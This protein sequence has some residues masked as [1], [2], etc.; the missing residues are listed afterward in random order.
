MNSLD[1]QQPGGRSAG[2]ENRPKLPVLFHLLDVSRPKAVKPPEVPAIPEPVVVPEPI[3]TSLPEPPPAETISLAPPQPQTTHLPLPA[4][5]PVYAADLRLS[6]PAFS[7]PPAMELPVS[8][9]QPAAEPVAETTTPEVT[10]EATTEPATA[11]LE[12]PPPAESTEPPSPRALSERRRKAK[13]KT[14]AAEDWFAAHGKYVALAFVVA[15]GATIYIA[16]SNR[17]T[18]PVPAPDASNLVLDIESGDSKR[19]TADY[20]P[21]S[22]LVND[23]SPNSDSPAKLVETAS[24]NSSQAELFPPTQVA[25]VPTTDE[26]TPPASGDLFPKNEQPAAQV[27]TRTDGPQQIINHTMSPSAAGAPPSTTPPA[28]TAPAPTATAQAQAAPDQGYPNTGYPTTGLPA[29]NYPTT[30][31]PVP[32]YPT[33]G[34]TANFAPPPSMPQQPPAY[35]PPQYPQPPAPANQYQ[36]TQQYQP[37]PYQQYP[38]QPPAQQPTYPASDYRSA[39]A[40]PPS[41]VPAPQ[42]AWSPPLPG[43]MP[44]QSPPPYNTAPGTRYERSGSG[45]Y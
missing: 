30:N 13:A 8:E 18:P 25:A 14:P 9:P 31:P 29:A 37:S 35:Q 16:R 41:G 39:F 42:S 3:A 23:S 21:A 34:Y 1:T 7:P 33:T 28:P 43:G 45:I 4:P 6:Q 24:A 11:A 32:T 44:P 20:K 40:P 17:R 22:T 27:A 2:S 10:P 26:K 12:T 15:L 36:P 19:A 5:A 38:S